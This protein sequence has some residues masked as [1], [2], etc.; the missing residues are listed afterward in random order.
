MKKES[1]F[2]CSVS[3]AWTKLTDCLP[4][5]C[6]TS[7]SVLLALGALFLGTA[8]PCWADAADP[9]LDRRA[10]LPGFGPIAYRA[11]LPG[12]RGPVLVLLHGIFAGSTHRSFNELLPLLDAAD[13]RVFL[14]DLPGTGDSASPKRT[15]DITV[16]DDFVQTF[17]E[18]VVVEPSVLV[19]ESILGTPAL[20]VAAL[21]TDLVK[22]VVLLSPTGVHTLA[23][24]PTAAQNKLFE[25]VYQHEL[26]GLLFYE[27]LLSDP[28]LRY[29]LD[30]AYY[31]KALVTEA[32]LDEYRL[33]RRR[34]GQRFISFSFVGGQLY[35]PLTDVA[36]DVK[37]PVL[38]I[39]GK[40]AE[41]PSPSVSPD[42]ADDF[43]AV[44]PDW[45]YAVIDN[46]GLSVQREAPSEVAAQILDFTK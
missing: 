13:A 45:S 10:D 28:S 32:L 30:R 41:S 24:P 17:L 4:I 37:V 7:V 9:V 22:G 20:K 11:P 36:Y 19:S 29:F 8:G 1:L 40:Q 6:S 39:F 25:S 43:R 46:A 16:F 27:V 44:R 15:Y 23:D 21:R 3:A 31:N 38:A 33:A 2:W 5:R 12:N 34:L 18:R 42:T 35:R 26:I 14:L